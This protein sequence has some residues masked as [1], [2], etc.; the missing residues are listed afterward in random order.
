MVRE[1]LLM[2]QGANSSK[3]GARPSHEAVEQDADATV[4]EMTEQE[5]IDKIAMES[6]RRAE[7]RI[8][9]DEEV[10]PEDTMFTK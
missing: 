6:A 5:R 1:V 10:N 4:E 9:A 7:N 3:T 8:L 2:A